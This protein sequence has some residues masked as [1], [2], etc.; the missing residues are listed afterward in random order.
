MKD[1]H[2]VIISHLLTEK[3]GILREKQN[4]YAF[5]VANDANKI[6]VQQAIEELFNVRVDSVRTMVVRGKFKRLGRFTGKRPNWKKAIV[7]LKEGETI[8]QLDAI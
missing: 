8:S 7:S 5:H 1:P 6:D 4:A 2:K 3:I